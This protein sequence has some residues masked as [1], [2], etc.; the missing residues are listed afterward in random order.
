LRLA[1]YQ[2]AAGQR[3]AAGDT[4]SRLSSIAGETITLDQIAP[5]ARLER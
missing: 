5:A 2:V 1:R 4:L 3:A